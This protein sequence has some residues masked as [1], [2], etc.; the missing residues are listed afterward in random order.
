LRERQQQGAVEVKTNEPGA[1]GTREH[2][3]DSE[4]IVSTLAKASGAESEDICTPCSKTPRCKTSGEAGGESDSQA[5]AAASDV[6]VL[7][8][9]MG[10]DGGQDSEYAR[11]SVRMSFLSIVA[12]RFRT[13]AR[14][15][16]AAPRAVGEAATG[17]GIAV[18]RKRG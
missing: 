9:R 5:G 4:S 11:H 17:G 6:S 10:S 18:A 8:V 1:A 7:P 15:S 13:G 2:T 12:S 14:V 3:Y 16:Q